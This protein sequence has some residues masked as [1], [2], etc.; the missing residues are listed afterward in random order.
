MIWTSSRMRKTILRG[1]PT[2]LYIRLLFCGISPHYLL[3]LQAEGFGKWV[4][5][6]LC[7]YQ[8]TNESL[9]V[10]LCPRQVEN[11]VM[12]CN[13][14]IQHMAEELSALQLVWS[15]ASQCGIFRTVSSVFFQK[16]LWFCISTSSR[17]LLS[18]LSWC[19][20]RSAQ[21]KRPRL[22]GPSGRGK[23]WRRS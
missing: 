11:V 4:Q 19:F 18:L 21:T 5:S 9:P 7:N 2:W 20:R 14:R 15:W 16:S 12:H 13:V 8:E 23:Q 1:K 3:A 6:P 22:T 17:L 10:W